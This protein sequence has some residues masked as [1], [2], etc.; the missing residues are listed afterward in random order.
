MAQV[1]SPEQWREV[2]RVFTLALEREVIPL[3]DA[4]NDV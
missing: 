2:K 3:T 1:P 4:P